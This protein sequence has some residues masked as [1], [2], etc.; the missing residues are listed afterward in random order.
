MFP[1]F[2]S[3]LKY[4][5][6]EK[7]KESP[8][9]EESMIHPTYKGKTANGG[10][11][12]NEKYE[13]FG[14]SVLN[15]LLCEILFHKF[16]LENEGDLAKRKSHLA[17]RKIAQIAAENIHLKE[18]IKMGDGLD[19]ERNSILACFF[20]VLIC[21]IYLEYGL[22]KT[23]EIIDFLFIKTNHD[24]SGKDSKSTL[25][26][27]SQAKYRVLPVYDLISTDGCEHDPMF[28]MSVKVGKFRAQGTGKTKKIAQQNAAENLL[29][30]IKN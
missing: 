15:F 10:K 8:S 27:I 23:K 30:I 22:E 28:N 26:E 20:E 21:C 7:I 4:F 2:D 29:E 12:V 3:F 11:F 24:A 17:S 5:S 13:F 25:Q 16:P 1:D 19:L 18:G 9:F 6:I 14:D